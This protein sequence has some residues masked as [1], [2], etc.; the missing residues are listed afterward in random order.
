LPPS[1][2]AA[3]QLA[4][5][6]PAGDRNLWHGLLARMR[7][8]EATVSQGA[9]Q[10]SS[11]SLS[12]RHVWITDIR[13]IGKEANE[14]EL[15]EARLIAKEH[16]YLTEYR[17]DIRDFPSEILRLIP[18]NSIQM[19]L[20][21]SRRYA[22]SLRSGERRPSTKLL[23]KVVQFTAR[24]AR[25]SLHENREPRIP[26]NDEEAILRMVNSLRNSQDPNSNSA[27]HA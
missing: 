14:L 17:R 1:K 9:A 23:P 21:C 16:R 20:N 11:R 18:T 22:Y 19:A 7:E 5:T 12:R 26:K 27:I 13:P 15:I 10:H 6:D 4:P 8:N 3:E 24:Y 2:R 25:K